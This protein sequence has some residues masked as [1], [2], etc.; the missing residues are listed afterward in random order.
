[1]EYLC[2]GEVIFFIWVI[3][4]VIGDIESCVVNNESIRGGESYA[5]EE[6][7]VG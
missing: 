4:L 6:V 5:R 7:V 2:E 3:G 1:M